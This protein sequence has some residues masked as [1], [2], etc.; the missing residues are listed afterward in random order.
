M[1]LVVLLLV[2]WRAV[3]VVVDDDDDSAVLNVVCECKS[4]WA[5]VKEDAFGSRF[6]KK[7]VQVVALMREVVILYMH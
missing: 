1:I 7:R 5:M 4:L 3:A 2:I 6:K